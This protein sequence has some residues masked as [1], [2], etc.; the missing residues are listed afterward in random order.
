MVPYVGLRQEAKE[1]DATGKVVALPGVIVDITARK[2][3]E[4]RYRTLFNAMDQGFA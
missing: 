2:Q 4:E 3:T 1:Q